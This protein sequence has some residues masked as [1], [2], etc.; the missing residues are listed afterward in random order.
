MPGFDAKFTPDDE[1]EGGRRHVSGRRRD[2]FKHPRA[3]WVRQG[4]DDRNRM[5]RRNGLFGGFRQLLANSRADQIIQW[6]RS[7]LRRMWWA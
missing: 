1:R 3:P 7:F 5:D 2:V 4:V 6:I